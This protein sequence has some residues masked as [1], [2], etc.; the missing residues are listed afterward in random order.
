MLLRVQGTNMG[1]LSCG[2]SWSSI[3]QFTPEALRTCWRSMG[4]EAHESAPS[5]VSFDRIGW[6]GQ[7]EWATDT[8][9]RQLQTDCMIGAFSK[10]MGEL[11]TD[12]CPHSRFQGMWPYWS[13]ASSDLLLLLQTCHIEELVW[14][15]I[16]Q[17]HIKHCES[18]MLQSQNGDETITTHTH[19]QR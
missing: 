10:H 14:S 9:V 4:I 15:V 17:E 18:G 8:L 7:E 3:T 5:L 2:S 19:M 13:N 1:G 12:P 6:Y 16:L 11:S